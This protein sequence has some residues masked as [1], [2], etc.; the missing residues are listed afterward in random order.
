MSERT[1]LAAAQ[2]A[3]IA[4][5]VTALV[6]AQ[7]TAAKILAFSIP[8][9]LP[10]TGA[11]L[12]LPG[13]ALAY[14]LTFFASDCYAELYGKRAAQVMVNVA[15][16]MNGVLLVLIWSTILA[17]A[18][19]TS[20]DPTQF[21]QVLG[22]STNIVIASLAAYLVSQNWD[23]IVFHRLREATD[24]DALWLRNVASTASSQLIDTLIFVTLGF[25]VIPELLGV[26]VAPPLPVIASLIV[27]QYLLKLLIALVDTPFVYAVVGFVRSRDAT[28]PTTEREPQ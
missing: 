28:I 5:F 21:R 23:V 3:L 26:G 17:P 27:G 6:T 1:P 25:L 9:S 20:I 14:A 13:A 7:V 8:V 19:A 12:I 18:A 15:F 10:V 4:L 24:G 22:A 11:T 16:L 2:V